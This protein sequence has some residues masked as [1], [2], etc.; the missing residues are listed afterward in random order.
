MNPAQP[1]GGQWGPWQPVHYGDWPGGRPPKPPKPPMRRWLRVLLTLLIVPVV[2]VVVIVIAVALLPDFE[3][4][5]KH[6]DIP[7]VSYP[8]TPEAPGPLLASLREKPVPGWSVDLR[9]LHPEAGSAYI[10]YLGATGEHAFFVSETFSRSK[11]PLV[12]HGWLLGLDVTTGR[13]L[14]PAVPTGD[15]D[16]QCYRNGPH[17][18]LCLSKREQGTPGYRYENYVIDADS[19]RVLNHGPTELVPRFSGGGP[20]E[21]QQV[22]DYAV[23]AREGDGIHGIGDDGRPSWFSAGTGRVNIAVGGFATVDSGSGHYTVLSLADGT[24]AAPGEGV[25][26]LYAD[27][28]AVNERS[29]HTETVRF[30]DRSG[31]QIG[32]YRLPK[33]AS[34]YL[35][36]DGLLPWLTFNLYQDDETQLIFDARGVP[37]VAVRAGAGAQ[38][39]KLIGANVY[40]EPAGSSDAPTAVWPKY[41]LRTGERVSACAGLP[42]SDYIGSDGTVVL[43]RLRTDAASGPAIAVDTNTCTTLWQIDEPSPM[44]AIGSTLVTAPMHGTTISALVPPAR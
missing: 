20:W 30:Y 25:P 22:G 8:G 19:G 38:P 21:V 35:G 42:L 5:G 39:S 43:G 2:L 16:S 28:F 24:V 40:V 44:W 36:S 1:P 3:M 31:A 14:F 34:A 10:E 41:S 15:V 7:P 9:E 11:D 4:G 37:M 27:G 23:I 13:Q 18:V 26:Y 33:G 12:R 17:R 6:V 29:K 32:E